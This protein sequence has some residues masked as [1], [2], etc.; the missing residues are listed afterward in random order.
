MYTTPQSSVQQLRIDIQ[1]LRA[2]L[3]HAEA[4]FTD[5]IRQVHPSN[6]DSARNLVHYMA[7]RSFDLRDLQEQLSEL[8]IS[9]FAHAE[10]YILHNL[11]GIEKLLSALSPPPEVL[12]QTIPTTPFTYRTYKRKLR[13]NAIGLFGHHSQFQKRSWIMV[14]MPKEATEGPDLIENMLRGGMNI[15]RINTSHD[16]PEV[17]AKMIQYIRQ[18]E[19]K[20]GRLC[21]VYFDLAG[22]KLRTIFESKHIL[23][24]KRRNKKDSIL[25]F[26][27]DY[28]WVATDLDSLSQSK[29]SVPKDLI[30]VIG[31]TLPQA[32][33]EVKEGASIYFDDGKI[34]GLVRQTSDE[35]IL[36]EITQSAVKGSRLRAQKGI[37]L[38][39][40]KLHIP[41]LTE[42][43][44]TYLPFIAEYGDIVG[45]SFVRTAADVHQLQQELERLK[46]TD[47]GLV[48]K[49]ENKEAF[50]NLP[51][52]LLAAMRS[53]KAGVMIARGDLAVELGYERI[54]EVQEE[55]L[56]ICEAAHLPNIWATQV[57]ESLAQKGLATRSEITDAAMAVR[58]E[59]V[60]L[61]KGEYILDALRVLA[62]ILERMELHLDKKHGSFRPLGV[63]KRF[64][65]I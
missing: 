10:G 47:M 48:L 24:K 30:A 5:A 32:L 39:D 14:T 26:K 7:L 62:N 52:L 42:N 15:A 12:T 13:E 59:C 57:L 45:Y 3:V 54:A 6:R 18:A 37:N 21:K 49:I 9:S 53:S 50:D 25:L 56:W 22:P 17:W 38:P 19:Q 65:Q 33:A 35:G 61:N 1:Q 51:A 60:M 58:A 41:S 29:V 36:V 44:F 11:L 2:A 28:I 64:L 46:R 16:D 23:K 55:I 8:S 63:A 31:I 34:G 20:T 27:G 4:Q 43:D 40:T